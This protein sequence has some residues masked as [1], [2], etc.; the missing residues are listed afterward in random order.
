MR[1]SLAKNAVFNVIYQS[2]NVLFPLISATYVARI[3]SPS[4]MGD[5]GYAQ[6]IVSYFVMIAMLG[7]PTY[8]TR[9][10]AKCGED[11]TKLNKTFSELFTINVIST[12]V[13]MVAYCV[14]IIGFV[15]ENRIL[16][17]IC[18]L[19]L[20]FNFIN[21]D[22]FYKGREDFVYIAIRSI[23]VK[24]MSMLFLFTLVKDRGDCNIYALIV[25]AAN[26]C[27]YIFNVLR[28]RKEVK[29]VFGGLCLKKHMKSLLNLLI[30]G[31]AGSLYSKIDVTMLGMLSTNVSV[32]LYSTAFKTINIAIGVVAS[33]TSIFLPRIS[34]YYQ[35]DRERFVEYVTK[36]LQIVLFISVPATIGITLLSSGLMT[37]LFGE[38]YRVGHSVIQI[39]SPLLIIR[40][41]GDILCYQVLISTGKEK[42]LL[43]SYMIAASANIVLN[44]ILIPHI[45]YNG[46][47]LASVASELI[48]NVSLLKYSFQ[49]VRPKLRVRFIMGIVWG[50]LAM[51]IG[52]ILVRFFVNEGLLNLIGSVAA[53]CLIY[54]GI[55]AV[56]KNDVMEMILGKIRRKHN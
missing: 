37:E 41:V 52:V 25:C 29:F 20:L 13:C 28:L 27:N 34:Y 26:G 51:A 42:R 33:S 44:A 1:K 14:T 50:S 21:V 12:A 55:N 8:G 9:E 43:V 17:L 2:L 24:L 31:I 38:D 56:L 16:F 46:A 45:G 48:V 7:M 53:G 30:C 10:I 15:Q 54:F 11:R 40:G 18:G 3:L 49:E 47:A 6:N 32:G 35:I 39:L 23:A 22:W 36:G 4:G 5:V 19:E